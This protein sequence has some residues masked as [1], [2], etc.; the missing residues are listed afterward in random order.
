MTLAS[1]IE[2]QLFNGIHLLIILGGHCP[3]NHNDM[4]RLVHNTLEY[5]HALLMEGV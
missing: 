3:N 1:N 5:I 2:N 4:P